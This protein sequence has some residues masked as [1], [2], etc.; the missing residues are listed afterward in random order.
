MPP[1]SLP[2]H[3]CAQCQLLPSPPPAGPQRQRCQP[4]GCQE[5]CCH[6][7]GPGWVGAMVMSDSEL[8]LGLWASEGRGREEASPAGQLLLPAPG[9]GA[10]PGLGQGTASLGCGGGGGGGCAA[11]QPRPGTSSNAPTCTVP[12]L[13]VTLGQVLAKR[14]GCSEGWTAGGALSAP[15]SLWTLLR[16]ELG[17]PP[18]PS[19]WAP[20]GE[21]SGSLTAVRAVPPPENPA[22][23]G[24]SSGD[25]RPPP[26]V[27][28]QSGRRRAERSV[29]PPSPRERGPRAGVVRS[30]AWPPAVSGARPRRAGGGGGGGRRGE[31]PRGGGTGRALGGRRGGGGGRG[32]PAAGAPHS[33]HFGRHRGHGL[34]PQR[35]PPGG[36]GAHGR[37]GGG[38][39]PGLRARPAPAASA[40]VAAPRR[41]R[42]WGW[43]SGP[44]PAWPR[45]AVR[46]SRRTRR[47]RPGPGAAAPPTAT[48]RTGR[49]RGSAH[50]DV[51]PAGGRP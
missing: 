25:P 48:S 18:P 38:A 14:S 51:T 13:R 10:G 32:A 11:D 15:G 39:S 22:R 31:E 8:L 9:P 16:R 26:R 5:A 40:G 35:P 33:P 24:R 29:R 2:L 21:G 36:G 45:R 19:P 17:S 34:A 41:G 50:R 44:G 3:P 28:V 37:G 49:A 27:P 23:A 4:W 20:A 30:G 46:E 7:N 12:T 42:S 43:G 1:P 47:A 6:A